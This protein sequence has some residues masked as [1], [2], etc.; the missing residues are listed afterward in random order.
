M[1]IG[2]FRFIAATL[3]L[4]VASGSYASI[5]EYFC[6][7]WNSAEIPEGWERIGSGK[8]I[9][10]P[11]AD[12][13]G[14]SDTWEVIEFPYGRS[15]ISSCGTTTE[16]GRVNTTLISPAVSIPASGAV[17][18][19]DVVNYNPDV[20][21]DNKFSIYTLDPVSGDK[22]EDE[23][24]STRIKANNCADPT[25]IAI[26]LTRLENTSARFVFINEGNSTG[27]LGIGTVR[28]MMYDASISDTT[29]LFETSPTPRR[30]S[31]AVSICSPADSFT[32]TLTAPGIE[33]SICVEA[34]SE[35]GYS[36][37]PL[38][39]TSELNPMIGQ[40]IPYSISITPEMPGAVSLIKRGTVAC[41]DG[42]ES[43]VV[44]EE[45]TGIRCGYCPLGTAELELYSRLYP[46]RFI[47][48][49]IHCTPLSSE[50]LQAKGYADR[51]V[52]NPRFPITSLPKAVINRRT[53][54]SPTDVPEF[55]N[56]ISSL[57]SQRSIAKVEIDRVN[58]DFDSG[59]VEVKF[60][61]TM[62][63]DLSD[64]DFRAAAV[65]TADNLTGESQQWI[66]HNYYTGQKRPDYIND[67]LWDVARFYYEY[68]SSMVSC[69]DHPFNHVAMGIFPD[70][71]GAPLTDTWIVS[72]PQSGSLSFTMPFQQEK[73]G[74]GVQDARQTAVTVMII[75]G[76]NGEIIA[77]QKVNADDFNHDITAID[78]ISADKSDGAATYYNLQGM[79]IDPNDCPTG[80]Y[81]RKSGGMVKKILIRN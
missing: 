8:H 31:A 79:K 13:I 64:M 52:T 78:R 2:F 47:G 21:I 7:E 39:F 50:A 68:P 53:L 25:H 57:L 22:S 27:L 33:E 5:P 62:A 1:S 43:V 32:A 24:F 56:T 10:G 23:L 63:A 46:E 72:E 42:F 38:P 20:E 54:T 6:Q 26:P 48:V 60:S 58:C 77:A 41:G 4:S 14:N 65:L 37:Y 49:G 69:I 76:R 71:D 3:L 51:F 75:D 19:I 36:L 59:N 28:V 35:S 67:E 61:V 80:I 29:T 55:E 73:N 18:S 70:F 12:M 81:I 74:F 16:G 15:Y 17:L 9:T 40:S 34:A 11:T 44:E 45:G 66:Q 30:V